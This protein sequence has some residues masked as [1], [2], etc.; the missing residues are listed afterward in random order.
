VSGD[1]PNILVVMSDQHAADAM[2]CAGHPLV[3]TPHMDR[4]AEQGSRMTRCYCPSPL[5]VPSRMSFMTGRRPTEN[6]VV[7]NFDILSSSIMTWP[8]RLSEAGYHSALLGRMHFEGPDQFHGFNYTISELRHWSGHRPIENQLETKYVPR[9]SYW[10]PRESV[11]DLSGSGRTFVQFRDEHVT[12]HACRY[13]QQQA[14]DASSQ[15]FAAVVGLYN[16]HPPYVGRRD[17]F[18][19]YLDRVD[20]LDE[21]LEA[22][23]SHLAEYY[24]DF[25]NW[26]TPLPIPMDAKRRALAAYLANVEHVD[27]QLGRVLKKLDDAGLAEN[28]LV[29]YCSD[30]G[31]MLGAKGVWGKDIMYDPAARVPMIA[32]LPG[33]TPP[34]SEINQPCNLRDLG[35]TFCDLAGAEPLAGSDAPSMLPMLRG[36]SEDHDDQTECELIEG[37]TH[38]GQTRWA[39]FKILIRSHWKLWHTHIDGE[40]F[41]S[42]FD[43]QHDPE[44]REDLID[45]PDHAD[46]IA[47][48]KKRLQHRW[49]PEAA[50][51]A[52]RPRA[53][54]RREVDRH[55]Q[56]IAQP[57]TYAVPEHLDADVLTLWTQ[58]LTENR[59]YM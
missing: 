34:G 4:L 39:A 53:E 47:T 13:L 33:L 44:E 11:I 38:F 40:D 22:M 15:P 16:P 52:A 56:A 50:I 49:S 41:W 24:R 48:M 17:L 30:H 37:P 19:Y 59:T 9:W 45:C 26:Q 36:Q 46:L 23:P 21:T 32:R 29:I 31:D 51:A 55:W 57:A 25:H 20:P 2:G 5:C 58:G 42:L 8:G 10:S 54:N 6:A 18:E 7:N 3:R 12:D 14:D 35:N 27:E 1:R 43:L 28:T